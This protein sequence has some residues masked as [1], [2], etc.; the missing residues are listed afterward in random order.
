MGFGL[1]WVVGGCF[2]L[3]LVGFGW[4]RSQVGLGWGLGCVWLVRVLYCKVS[5]VGLSTGLVWS[6][7]RVGF[8][9]SLGG[10]RGLAG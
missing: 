9:I 3:V 2:D 4:V 10:F 1:G 5:K 6:G 7:F 8:M